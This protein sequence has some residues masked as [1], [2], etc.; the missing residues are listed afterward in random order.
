MTKFRNKKTGEIYNYCDIVTNTTN[1]DDGQ[2]MVLYQKRLPNGEVYQFVRDIS[3]F[4]L[5]FEPVDGESFVLPWK[6]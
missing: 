3:E 6:S 1:K 4:I 2:K 5:K